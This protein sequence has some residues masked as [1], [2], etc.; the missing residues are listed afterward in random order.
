M[1][2][3]I[4]QYFNNKNRQALRRKI[5]AYE[6]FNQNGESQ[7]VNRLYTA[8]RTSQVISPIRFFKVTLSSETI[9]EYLSYKLFSSNLTEYLYS[10]L[11]SP[12]EYV[13][14]NNLPS[15]WRALLEKQYNIRSDR[16][17]FLRWKLFGLKNVIFSFVYGLTVIIGMI[18][19][20]RR[21]AASGVY[22]DGLSANNIPIPSNEPSYT[23][24]DYYKTLR[25]TETIFANINKTGTAKNAAIIPVYS[26]FDNISARHA[27]GIILFMLALSASSI[28]SIVLGRG[29]LAAL[30]LEILKIKLAELL[31][32][33]S[34][35][36][37][38]AFYN[39]WSVYRP[40]WTY[41][42]EQRGALISLYF[43]SINCL[44]FDIDNKLLD[45][46]FAYERMSWTNYIIWNQAMIPFLQL[47]SRFKSTFEVTD[48][49]TFSDNNSNVP[50]IKNKVVVFD[51]TPTRSALFHK[52]APLTDYYSAKTKN[53]FYT[54]IAE[55]AKELGIKLIFKRKRGLSVTTSKRYLNQIKQLEKLDHIEFADPDVSAHRLIKDCRAVL[56]MPFTS[57]AHI[58]AFFDKPSIYYDGT[59]RI[60]NSEP[61]ALGITMINNKKELKIW[62]QSI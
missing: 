53:H 22:L 57:T 40:A 14:P 34:I 24:I 7:A 49:V 2:R 41:G 27:P 48:P 60:S 21:D 15:A 28:V 10:S 44:P 38:Y 23:I 26:P 31:D 9:C 17:S 19:T 42:L 35:C 54:D 29:L 47:N 32:E 39:S 6:R 55:I 30:S 58:G 59:G 61:T 50:S 25:S 1:L 51:V 33:H 11:L 8:L 20:R 46:H 37:E 3:S 12:D 5:K 52:Y 13:L 43:Y 45:T 16:L 56:S 62:L 36:K 4:C 18:T